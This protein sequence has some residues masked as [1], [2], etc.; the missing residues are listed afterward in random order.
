MD[1]DALQGY[2]PRCPKMNIALA[3]GTQTVVNKNSTV[4]V[5]AT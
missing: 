1:V 5:P 2:K 3:P 4:Y